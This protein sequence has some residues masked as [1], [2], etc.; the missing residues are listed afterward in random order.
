MGARTV[1]SVLKTVRSVGKNFCYFDVCT[2]FVEANL[3]TSRAEVH[4]IEKSGMGFI[5]AYYFVLVL[6][7]FPTLQ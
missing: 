1:L 5:N 6:R 7:D 2:R 4:R 3:G